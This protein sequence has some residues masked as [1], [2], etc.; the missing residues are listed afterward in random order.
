MS[1]R[2]VFTKNSRESIVIAETTFNGYD[3]IDIRT[4]YDDKGELKPTRKG[5]TLRKEK[6]DEFVALLTKFAKDAA[7]AS[8]ETEELEPDSDD[9]YDEFA[10]SLP[11]KA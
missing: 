7:K 9:N 5:V 11:L 8:S 4:F 10:K 2:S 1:E 6:L 3:L